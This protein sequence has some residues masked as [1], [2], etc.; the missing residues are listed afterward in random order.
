[1]NHLGTTTDLWTCIQTL[2]GHSGE[3]NAGE[4]SPDGKFLLSASD[5][6]TLR[7]FLVSSF[8]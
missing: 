5:D 8:S 3:V 1:M 7:V 4:W 2:E 6:K